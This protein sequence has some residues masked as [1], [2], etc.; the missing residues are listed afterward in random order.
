MN[1]LL[2]SNFN[3]NED[4]SEL[5]LNYQEY[6]HFVKNEN[7]SISL[8]LNTSQL[9]EY[10][11]QGK[12]IKYRKFIFLFL[13]N[14]Y[15][16]KKSKNYQIHLNEKNF[17]IIIN[18]NLNKHDINKINK[19]INIKKY[20]QNNFIQIKNKNIIYLKNNIYIHLKNKCFLKKEYIDDLRIKIIPKGYIIN[21]YNITRNII[22][23]L[24]IINHNDF[25]GKKQKYNFKRTKCNLIVVNKI[26]IN[27]WFK[28]IKELLPDS[29][30]IQINSNEKLEDYN[31]HDIINSDFLLI[32]SALF[33]NQFKMNEMK[34][35][36]N[37]E[38]ENEQNFKISMDNC[39]YEELMNNNFDNNAF[40]NIYCFSWL[41]LII[42][43]IEKLLKYEYKYSNY[44]KIE[45]DNYILSEKKIDDED[46]KQISHLI[47][48]KNLLEK[49]NFNNF[50]YLIKNE[51]LFKN[52]IENNKE[53]EI[54]NIVDHSEDEDLIQ[55][56]QFK[57]YHEKD[58]SLLLLR[59]INDFFYQ[60]N[61]NNLKNVI[62]NENESDNIVQYNRKNSFIDEIM[63]NYQNQYFCC[64]CMERIEKNNM[65][66][67]GCCHYFC[68][69]CIVI[70]K[71][72]EQLSCQK[73]KCPM[74]RYEY[75]CI[76]NLSDSN[77]KLSKSMQLLEDI[78]NNEKNNNQKI[79]II[80]DF[81]E[82]LSYI[83]DKF[84]DKFNMSYYKKK[85]KKNI[86][87]IKT[88]YLL[89]Q[90][91]EDVNIYI[92]IQFKNN[93]DEFIKIKNVCEAFSSD[94]KNT[95][96]YLIQYSP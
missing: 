50:E 88:N 72:N 19:L 1:E 69:N 62:L 31:N 95:K 67:L 12:D 4:F 38:I 37:H 20:L 25:I 92:Y 36:L 47:I 34:Y 29:K 33:F 44:L 39:I 9:K 73:S 76:Y 82:C 42:D 51:L 22:Y 8:Y 48:E 41:N 17:N 18:K 10:L 56:I 7:N 60:N 80:N 11:V 68:K 74:C 52:N 53:N 30:I 40:K 75:P 28:L 86:Q 2:L 77:I 16:H 87:L 96:F 66:L 90:Y 13:E 78:L 43:D 91:I 5:L 61:E 23:L 94:I 71:M 3:N 21:N 6:F 27:I 59:S 57:K 26:K 64:I 79:L 93:Q 14:I 15:R 45:N 81:N 55:Q 84:R 58:I 32:N 63:N 54:I 46:L 85:N 49:Y 70:H 24:N 65:C 35:N 83:E 89:K